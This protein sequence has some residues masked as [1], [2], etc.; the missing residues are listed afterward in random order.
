MQECES[1]QFACMIGAIELFKDKVCLIFGGSFL[2]FLLECGETLMALQMVFL[3]P[4]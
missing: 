2:H 4:H 3:C 1:K